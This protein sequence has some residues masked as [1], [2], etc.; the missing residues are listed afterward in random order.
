MS[1]AIIRFIDLFAGIGGFRMSFDRCG[2]QCVFSS[3]FNEACQ[4]I[5]EANY[6]EKPQGDITK[7]DAKDVP[8]FDILCAGFPCQPFSICGKKWD[9][10]ILGVLCFLMYAELSKKNNQR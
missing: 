9:L 1:K 6:G 7:I 3:E 2:C 8:D 5:Y 10:M 4:K